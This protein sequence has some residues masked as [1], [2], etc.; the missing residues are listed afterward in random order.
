MLLNCMDCYIQETASSCS[1]TF[2]QEGRGK[3]EVSL[4]LQ[5]Q[6]TILKAL[7]GEAAGTG[8]MHIVD[9]SRGTPDCRFW[10]HTFSE[11]HMSTHSVPFGFS[12][13]IRVA[14]ILHSSDVTIIKREES[15][16]PGGENRKR[17]QQENGAPSLPLH[18]LYPAEAHFNPI[19]PKLCARHTGRQ[20]EQKFNSTRAVLP[21]RSRESQLIDKMEPHQMKKNRQIDTTLSTGR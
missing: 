15:L 1:W 9:T 7:N 11:S 16:F 2:Q 3:K 17:I 6:D 5:E 13:H 4:Q 12:Q 20:T 21:W 18:F 14:A 10:Y 8:Q 19:I